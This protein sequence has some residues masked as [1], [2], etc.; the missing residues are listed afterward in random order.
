P[1][2]PSTVIVWPFL[3]TTVPTCDPTT[4]GRS[5]SRATMAQCDSTP[6]TSDTTAPATE[7]RGT[8]G[9]R[10]ISHTMMS[11]S[12]R[13]PASASDRT[14]R[15]VPVYDPGEPATPRSTFGSV[16]AA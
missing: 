6:P 3:I 7:N 4:A 13:S 10:V 14:T 12:S 1:L 11:P 9:G 15:A 16:F 5:N 8:H 2:V